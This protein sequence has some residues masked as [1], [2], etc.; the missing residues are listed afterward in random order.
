MTDE[1]T[2][3]AQTGMGAHKNKKNIPARTGVNNSDAEE[4]RARNMDVGESDDNGKIGTPN[5]NNR[6]NGENFT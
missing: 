3:I 5:L 6:S 4:E 1:P 2:E